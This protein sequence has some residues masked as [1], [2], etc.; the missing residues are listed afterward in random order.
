MPAAPLECGT[1]YTQRRAGHA[2]A[3]RGVN[4]GEG[5]GAESRGGE[6]GGGRQGTEP[7]ASLSES[8]HHC[9][10]LS[11]AYILRIPRSSRMHD[12]T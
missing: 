6:E 1:G 12:K 4:V 10:V 11:V 9:T 8:K 3:I 2:V 7:D 5:G